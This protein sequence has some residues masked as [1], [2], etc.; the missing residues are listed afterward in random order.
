MWWSKAGQKNANRISLFSSPVL[1]LFLLLVSCDYAF[2][3][4]FWHDGR[5]GLFWGWVYGMGEFVGI[6]GAV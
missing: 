5:L 3:V 4:F 2:G 1:L 6:M